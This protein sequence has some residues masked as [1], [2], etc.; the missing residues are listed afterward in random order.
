MGAMYT[1]EM[2]VV[3]SQQSPSS[4]AMGMAAH[5]LVRWPSTELWP[6]QFSR[7]SMR[8]IA[9]AQHVEAKVVDESQKLQ[10]KSQL[11]R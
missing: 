2:I 1:L 8:R 9:S 10:K 5:R 3:P 7:L 6:S 4:T 11:D